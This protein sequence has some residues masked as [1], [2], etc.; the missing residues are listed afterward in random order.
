M[1]SRIGLKVIDET[2]MYKVLST[3]SFIGQEYRM[4]EFLME[5]AKE[6]NYKFGI[7][8]KNN[9]YLCKGTTISISESFSQ[10][11]IN[12]KRNDCRLQH[13]ALDVYR[14]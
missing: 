4:V 9:V 14:V 13:I 1:K 7:D 10:P 2:M 8:A 11:I 5:Y 12:K 6:M 3:P